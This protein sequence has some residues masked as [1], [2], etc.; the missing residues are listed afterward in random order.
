MRPSH[1]A[2]GQFEAGLGDQRPG[3]PA[4][5]A[6]AGTL[7]VTENVLDAADVAMFEFQPAGVHALEGDL[8]PERTL[9][10]IRPSPRKP[11]G[12]VGERPTAETLFL[13]G[14]AYIGT[15]KENG[16]EETECYV[17]ALEMR[18]D[19]AEAHNNLGVVM[20]TKGEEGQAAEHYRQ[21]IKI[22]P[23][24]P[25]A[26]YNYAVLLHSRGNLDG[27]ADRYLE[28]LRLRPEYV[29]AHYGLGNLRRVVG[30][31]GQAEQHFTEAL[32]LRP[33]YAEI[34]RDPFTSRL[35]PVI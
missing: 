25:E 5:A 24:Y 16:L 31:A 9:Y 32:R 28:A 10:S 7:L 3:Q 11:P 2:Q 29:D 1:G 34:K 12:G 17:R 30:E 22:R 4:G 15:A 8:L 19:Y 27:A 33:E 6:D 18:P 26:H 23:W 21:A 14:V 13:A 20:R 35:Q